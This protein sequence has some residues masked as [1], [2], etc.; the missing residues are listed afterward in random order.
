MRRRF[1]LLRVGGI[2]KAMAGMVKCSLVNTRRVMK[3]CAMTGVKK[4]VRGSWLSVGG[5]VVAVLLVVG[6]SFA[7]E[8]WSPGQPPESLDGNV[9]M[10]GAGAEVVE[11]GEFGSCESEGVTEL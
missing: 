2:A 8:N 9:E 7:A 3:A 5:T 10:P 6:S 11:N 4:H 1:P